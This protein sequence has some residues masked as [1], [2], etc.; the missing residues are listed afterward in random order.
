MGACGSPWSPHGQKSWSKPLPGRGRPTADMG[1]SFPMLSP[2]FWPPL[3]PNSALR[4]TWGALL[5]CTEGHHKR[6]Q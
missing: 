4:V 6:L 2:V 3:V 5:K 1:D